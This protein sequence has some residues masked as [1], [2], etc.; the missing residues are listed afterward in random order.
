M[1]QIEGTQ[2]ILHV[3]QRTGW[4]LYMPECPHLLLIRLFPE[5]RCPLLL[6]GDHCGSWGSTDFGGRCVDPA[7]Y[8]QPASGEYD[9][10]YQEMGQGQQSSCLV[11]LLKKSQ[12]AV[13]E[14]YGF[15][16]TDWFSHGKTFGARIVFCL[17]NSVERKFFKWNHVTRSKSENFSVDMCIIAL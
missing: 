2:L 5:D 3:Y 17:F 8:L 12:T 11:C 16:V 15:A 10:D 14:M 1:I 7:E 13:L 9:Q 6:S 4:F